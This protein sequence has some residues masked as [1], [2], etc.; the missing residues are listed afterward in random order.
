R[1]RETS[2]TPS[3]RGGPPREQGEPPRAAEV[4]RRAPRLSPDSAWAHFLLG[5]ALVRVERLP[6]ALAEFRRAVQL[7]PRS[8]PPT[9]PDAGGL[10]GPERLVELDDRLPAVLRRE[11]Q[12][13]DADECA[14][15]ALV[16]RFRELEAASARLY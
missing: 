16:C 6:E 13:R 3:V 10:R 11:S 1:R 14:E 12:P 7:K 2:A 8:D 5:G 4:F 9:L 15:F